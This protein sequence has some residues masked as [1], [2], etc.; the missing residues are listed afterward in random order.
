MTMT[1]DQKLIEL[2]FGI[3]NGYTIE[4][5]VEELERLRK[6]FHVRGVDSLL[7]LE[8]EVGDALQYK[9]AY[10]KAKADLEDAESEAHELERDIEALKCALEDATDDLSKYEATLADVTHELLCAQA[11]IKQLT[12][13][14]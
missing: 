6:V 14:A 8:H 3:S 11:K 5:C 12:E 10:E 4:D 13:E 1:T 9:D 2:V 7:S